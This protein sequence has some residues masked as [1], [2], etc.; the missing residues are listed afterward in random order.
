MGAWGLILQPHAN[1]RK[2]AGLLFDTVKLTYAVQA[3]LHM[4]YI[5]TILTFAFHNY[6][7]FNNILNFIIMM[8]AED[9]EYSIVS[10]AMN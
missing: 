3:A 10:E 6:D 4:Q 5:S 9:H 2:L 7:V 8:T 1:G